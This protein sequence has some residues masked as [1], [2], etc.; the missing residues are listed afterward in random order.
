[1]G[2]NCSVGAARTFAAWLQFYVRFLHRKSESAVTTA[3]EPNCSVS[4][5]KR[6]SAILR[7]LGLGGAIAIIASLALAACSPGIEK[8][9]AYEAQYD[10]LMSVQ[11]YPAALRSIQKAVDIDDRTARR[12][13]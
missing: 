13:I 7:R 10:H 2:S 1:M 4:V 11:A 12:Y 8:A 5:L 9:D 6:L 3:H